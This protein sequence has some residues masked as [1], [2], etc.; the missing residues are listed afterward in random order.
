[1]LKG[2]RVAIL[3][4]LQPMSF[5]GQLFMDVFFVLPDDVEGQ[6]HA[7]RVGPEIVPRDLQPGDRIIL[8]YLMGMVTS[9]TRVADGPA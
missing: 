3:R 5:H 8:S 2:S 7:A 9:I 1:M 6:V 4:R